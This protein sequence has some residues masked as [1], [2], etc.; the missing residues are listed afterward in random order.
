MRAASFSRR[1]GLSAM[2]Y[3]P[4]NSSTFRPVGHLDLANVRPSGDDHAQVGSGSTTD[5]C[6][7]TTSQRSELLS[8]FRRSLMQLIELRCPFC[9][10]VEAVRAT[11]GR[12]RLE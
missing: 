9:T 5:L 10:R 2:P 11:M 3:A 7:A 6:T 4:A 12:N 1:Q 8:R